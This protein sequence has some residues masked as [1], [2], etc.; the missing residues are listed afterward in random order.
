[1]HSDFLCLV[2]HQSRNCHGTVFQE[3]DVFQEGV[4]GFRVITYSVKAVDALLEQCTDEPTFG[5]LLT[6]WE[7]AI[8]LCSSPENLRYGRDQILSFLNQ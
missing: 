3:S 5:A 8:S 1:M 6:Q 4:H 2:F 7:N